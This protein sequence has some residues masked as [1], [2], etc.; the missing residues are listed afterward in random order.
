[1]VEESKYCREMIITHFNK[2]LVTNKEYNEDFKNSI[3]CWTCDDHNVDND[4]KVKD[5][6]HTTRKYRGSEHRYFNIK[7]KLNHGRT[8][9]PSHL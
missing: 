7:L 8:S 6:C 4:V 2:E 1:M 5:H 9:Q 3:K